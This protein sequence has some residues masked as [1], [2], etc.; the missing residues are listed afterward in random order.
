M[1]AVRVPALSE[2]LQALVQDDGLEGKSAEGG[3]LDAPGCAREGERSDV[4]CSFSDDGHAPAELGPGDAEARLAAR[5][6]FGGL[7][8]ERVLRGRSGVVLAIS[9][10]SR[11]PV[12]NL[13]VHT[14]SAFVCAVLAVQRVFGVF[15]RSLSA[16]GLSRLMWELVFQYVFRK[17][18]GARQ[19]SSRSIISCFV[20]WLSN[21]SLSVSRFC[22]GSM[23][24]RSARIS[25]LRAGRGAAVQWGF[26]SVTW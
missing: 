11:R 2:R 12:R 1:A 9:G 7:V 4:L 23:L 6:R 14:V 25:S 5:A 26:G 15:C 10:R 18:S 8:R 22:A 17:C 16:D 19:R 13:Y 3:L 21:W 20:V 24:W